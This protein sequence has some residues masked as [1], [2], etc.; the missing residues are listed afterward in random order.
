MMVCA[1][2]QSCQICDKS[3]LEV[4]PVT[5]SASFRLKSVATLEVL[6]VSLHAQHYNAIRGAV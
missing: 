4:R 5:N 6:R 1:E 2:D 3:T